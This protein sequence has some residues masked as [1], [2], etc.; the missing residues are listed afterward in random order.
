MTIDEIPCLR[1]GTCCSLYQPL[2][3]D[4]ESQRIADYLGMPLKTFWE[5]YSD[6]RWPI[7]GKHLIKHE[8]GHCALM[9]IE[10]KQHLCMVHLVKPD[11]CREWQESLEKKECKKGLLDQW[12]LTVSEDKTIVGDAKD[13]KRLANYLEE[14]A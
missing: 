9:Q 7:P 13:Q 8:D 2:V 3:T 1:C 6:P 10:G 11:D 4:E 12:N 5:Q 14:I